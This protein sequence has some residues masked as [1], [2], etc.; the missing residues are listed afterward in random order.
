MISKKVFLKG[1]NQD[2]A[3][4]LLDKSDYLNALNIRFAST[5]RG[6][7]GRLENIAGNVLKDLTLPAGVNQTIG[8]YEDT[9]NHRIFFFNKNSNGSH[10]IYCYDSDT[11]TTMTVLLSSQVTGGLG[12]NNFIHSVAMAGNLLYWTDGVNTR[13]INVEASIKLNNAGYVTTVAPYTSPIKQSVIS[14]I[15][16]QPW[17]PLTVVKAND[18]A[19]VNNFIKDNAVQFS[20]RFVYRDGEVSTF[21]PLSVLMN[22]NNAAENTAPVK[23]CIDVTIPLTQKIEQDVT[24][25][26]IAVR[27]ALDGA[28]SIIKEFTN[29]FTAHNSG[30]ALTFRYY[31]DSV[32]VAVDNATAVKPFD[33]V[34]LTT[35]TLEIAKN[36]LFLANNTDGYDTPTT[37]SLVAVA[38]S[39]GDAVVKGQWYK[40]VYRLGGVTQIRYVLLINDISVP[41]YY[42]PASQPTLP[43]PS[44]AVAFGTLTFIGANV[45]AIASYYGIPQSDV[46]QIVYQGPIVDVTGAVSTSIVGSKVFKSD[47]NYRVGIVFYDAAGRKSGVVAD[48]S[49]AIPDRTYD[50]VSFI[51]RINWSL[52]NN[53]NPTAQ[54]PVWATHY[55]IVRTKCLRTSFFEQL[56]ADS[57]H[58]IPKDTATGAYGTVK[59]TYAATDFGIAVRATSLFSNGLGYQYQEGDVLKL[60]V[61]GGAT[62]R[63][64]VK[65]ING[66]YIICDLVDLGNTSATLA[67]FE[68]YTPYIGL[69]NE[70]YYEV[71]QTYSVENAGENTRRF[72]VISGSLQ[73]DVHIIQRTL[74]STHLCEAMA[75]I[76]KYWKNWFTDLGRINIQIALGTANKPVSVYYSNVFIPGT[77]TNGLSTFE[78]LSQTNLPTDL[79]QINRLILTSKVQYEGT[80]LLAIGEQETA[81]V[82]VGESQV[83]DNTGNSFLATTSGVIGNVNIMKGSYG[84]IHPESASKWKGS[85]VFFDAN[86]GA[87]VRYDVNGLFPIS[88][89]KMERY[90][91]LVGQDLLDYIKNPAEYNYASPDLPLRVLGAVDPYHEEFICSMPRMFLNPKNTILE[92]IQLGSTS[93]NFTTVAA[94]LTP[95]VGSLAFSYTVGAGPS[96][97]SLFTFTG[98][99]LQLGGTITV[100]GTTDFE[101]SSDNSAFV[102]SLSFPYTGTSITRTVYVRM[103]SGRAVGSYGS[104]NVSISG[105]T[106]TASVAVSGTVIASVTPLIDA[107]PN[108]LS[109]FTY[110]DGSGPSTA[111]SF[112]IFASALSPA[113]GNITINPTTQY[114]I[115]T[116]SATAGFSATALTLAYTSGGTLASNTV[117]V[118]LKAGQSVGTYNSQS[119][120]LSGG[121]GSDSVVCN[122]QVTS[123]GSTPTVYS[124]TGSGYGNSSAEACSM[125]GSA[126]VALTSTTDPGSFGVGAIVFTNPLG[127]NRLLGYTSVFM[128]GANWDLNPSNG[129]VIAYSSN[130]C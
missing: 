48:G 92:D 38:Q 22:Y 125:A 45:A 115:S 88:S 29:G 14:L 104:Q 129:V 36:R 61:S 71:G 65:D 82:Y 69:S 16:N 17:A 75:P 72:S 126:P 123:S 6:K 85:V 4:Q 52:D 102:S 32:G 127:T 54:I 33:S 95:S 84:T 119:V 70:P 100:N 7:V 80:V 10:G 103:K 26:E 2:D 47:A 12:F 31:A 19:Y 67:M 51:T 98:A 44:T 49:V 66:E 43:I 83:F 130:Q 53:N 106:A 74:P 128:N 39:G 27:Y 101:V 110:A 64:N 57:I 50:S 77:A 37:T 107:S 120:T 34:P 68:V 91:R 90:F 23:N 113:S 63:L 99:N 28:T 105:G 117:W 114:E 81:T 41:G 58:Y 78:A 55:S 86:K 30:T 111:Q 89:N 73:G 24:K 25:I 112:T 42:L 109:G 1:I 76:D 21:S 108:I 11:D 8:A 18:A 122:G 116:T 9:P 94:S 20:Y 96:T 93:Y 40:L 124:Y 5:E 15:R 97:S 62:Y 118:R 3:Y 60:Y 13:R 121:G 59:H 56:R 35:K 87:W 46:L 79:Y